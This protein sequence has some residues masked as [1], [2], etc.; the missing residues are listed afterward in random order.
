[1]RPLVRF[2]FMY[3][4]RLGVLDGVPGLHL[5]TLMANYEYMIGMLYKDKLRRAIEAR[6]NEPAG[7]EAV[8]HR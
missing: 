8:A 1:M 5:A 3:V 2:V 6:G 4:V 7:A